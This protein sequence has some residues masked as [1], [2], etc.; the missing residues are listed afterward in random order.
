MKNRIITS[1]SI[2]AAVAFISGCSDKESKA[3]A[4]LVQAISYSDG[5]P[6]SASAQASALEFEAAKG[7]RP[8]GDGLGLS[9][10]EIIM[11]AGSDLCAQIIAEYPTTQAALK[12]AE[13]KVQINKRLRVIGNQR[14]R[15]LFNDDN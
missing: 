7:N 5:T 6:P 14:V 13:L 10:H 9:E 15:S 4:L 3:Q 11:V 1:I 8:T 2:L 12:A